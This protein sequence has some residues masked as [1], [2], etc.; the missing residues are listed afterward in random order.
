[1]TAA[2]SRVA[3]LRPKV[4]GKAAAL[5]IAAE[6]GLPVPRLHALSVDDVA[7]LAAANGDARVVLT[8]LE[9]ALSELGDGPFAVRSSAQAE[10]GERSFA[11]QFESRLRVPA[12]GCPH[13]RRRHR[14]QC[15]R[16]TRRALRGCDRRGRR[17]I[18]VL[19]QR[20]VEGSHAGVAFSRDPLTF[21]P[22]VVVEAVAGLGDSLVGGQRTP[23][24]ARFDRDSV[25]LAELVE[26]DPVPTVALEQA[27][28]LALRCEQLFGEPQDIEW[29]F[30]GDRVWLLQARRLTGF[31]NAE[32]FSDTWSSEVWPGLIKPLVFDVGDSAVN[33]AWGRILTSLAGPIDVDWRRMAASP[34]PGCTSMS[35]CWVRVLARA[36]LPENTL[37]S[38]GRGEKPRLQEGS[39]WRLLLSAGRLL[40]FLVRNVRWLSYVRRELPPLRDRAAEQTARLGQ[41]DGPHDRR[42]DTGTSC[43]A[44]GHLVPQRADDALFAGPRPLRASRTEAVLGRPR[45][46]AE[47]DRRVRDGAAARP[48]SSEREHRGASRRGPRSWSRRA[49]SPPSR[50]GLASRTGAGEALAAMAGVVEELGPRRDGQHR[51]LHAL[52]AR[53]GGDALAAGFGLEDRRTDRSHEPLHRFGRR[54]ARTCGS[55]DRSPP[56]CCSAQVRGRA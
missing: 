55:S 2:A 5:L 46:A 18:A 25:E 33:A 4:G 47:R 52:L 31:E 15:C 6:E 27:A 3:A 30:D 28:R 9:A 12:A 20:M 50:H 44:R 40:R 37:E 21:Q 48:G 54:R 34:R 43:L 51:L 11:G 10:D 29:A 49:T 17:Q 24:R 36:G 19:V 8:E 22:E 16:R 35:R 7:T 32:V 23:T 53:R 42:T 38:I 26:R 45:P 39:W 56:S 13:R 41:A 14:R 1:M